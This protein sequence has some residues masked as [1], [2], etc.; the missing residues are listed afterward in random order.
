MVRLFSC[1][2][3]VATLTSCGQPIVSTG[4]VTGT[5]IDSTGQP[6]PRVAILIEPGR[7]EAIGFVTGEDGSF[8]VPKV[9][10]GTHSVVP[11]KDGTAVAVATSVDVRPR[12]SARVDFV[13]E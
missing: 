10:L 9:P 5:V 13:V 3:A 6:T 4:S 12:E 7:P 1:L 2:V 8:H 11:V